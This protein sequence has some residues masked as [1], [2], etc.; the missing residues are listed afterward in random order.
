MRVIST[1]TR[2]DP[3][4]NCGRSEV[5]GCVTKC[6]IGELYMLWQ[7]SLILNTKLVW[8]CFIVMTAKILTNLTNS[9]KTSQFVKPRL[10]GQQHMLIPKRKFNSLQF[11]KKLIKNCSHANFMSTNIKHNCYYN[12]TCLLYTSYLWKCSKALTIANNSLLV[13]Q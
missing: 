6:L 4:K 9:S 2:G 1:I 13:T 3:Q 11:Y 12:Y 7:Q 5:I 10:E 8:E